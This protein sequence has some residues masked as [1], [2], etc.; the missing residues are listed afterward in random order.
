MELL[1]LLVILIAL[2]VASLKWGIDS[3]D[4]FR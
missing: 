4:N 3:R 1:I 2:A